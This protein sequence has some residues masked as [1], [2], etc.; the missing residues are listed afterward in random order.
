MQVVDGTNNEAERTLRPAT[1]ARDTG[2]TDKTGNGTRRRTIIT[3]VLESLRLY[4][5]KYTL[6]SVVEEL[7]RW[8][9]TGRSCFE[10]LL[11]KLKLTLPQSTK[12]ILDQIF[13]RPT[14]SPAPS[15]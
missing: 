6:G 4:L 2:R 13:S 11:H 10:K 7:V 3:S 14:P 12:S 15:G 1:Q 5:P 9:A 8:E